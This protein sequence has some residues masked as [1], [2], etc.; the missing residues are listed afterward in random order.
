MTGDTST[1]SLVDRWA[2]EYSERTGRI[3]Y[4]IEDH[5]YTYVF[6]IEGGR[7]VCVSGRSHPPAAPRDSARQRGAPPPK[8]G[9]HRGHLI[10]H[11]MGGGLDI[12]LIHQNGRLNVSKAWREIER[13]AVEHPG[14]AVAVHLQYCGDSDRP[15]A[16]EYAHE[17][18]E[19][20]LVV[21]RFAN[22]RDPARS[23]AVPAP[24][25]HGAHAR[26]EMDHRATRREADLREATRDHDSRER[27]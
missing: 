15:F 19:R 11:S 26:L 7:V 6:D 5:G 3:V 18:P 23:E 25:R 17:D 14:T 2:R 12:N 8:P 24:R 4:E 1:K 16:I 9:D 13:Q 22:T 20:G 10:A 27:S 21:D